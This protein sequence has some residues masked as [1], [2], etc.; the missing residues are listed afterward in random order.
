[1]ETSALRQDLINRLN[2]L[3]KNKDTLS[4]N[5]FR[6]ADWENLREEV[7]DKFDKSKLLSKLNEIIAYVL[8]AVYGL[9]QL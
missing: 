6:Y 8:L 9:Y 4:Y 5:D 7:R 3:R 2:K 1:M